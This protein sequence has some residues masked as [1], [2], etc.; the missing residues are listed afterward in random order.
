[1]YL[2]EAKWIKQL[3]NGHRTEDSSHILTDT[4]RRVGSFL[5]LDFTPACHHVILT[6]QPCSY[7][8]GLSNRSLAGWWWN[9]PE[10]QRRPEVHPLWVI[11][12]LEQQ[13]FSA[14]APCSSSPSRTGAA[15]EG[16][17]RGWAAGSPAFSS[18]LKTD[19]LSRRRWPDDL[20]DKRSL[21]PKSVSS[22]EA[23]LSC[24]EEC[25]LRWL[26]G[27]GV[28]KSYNTFGMISITNSHRLSCLDLQSYFQLLIPE[29]TSQ[30]CM[31]TLERMFLI[32]IQCLFF[33][34]CCVFFSYQTPRRNSQSFSPAGLFSSSG[35]VIS[36]PITSDKILFVP[37]HQGMCHQSTVPLV[38]Q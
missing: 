14:R 10:Q 30:L 7:L 38:R 3:I 18:G 25:L 29:S 24:L 6:I 13:R 21:T 32:W 33:S 12:V 19:V 28:L 35:S 34:L 8:C 17:S 26:S 31:L 2:K 27:G 4:W 9:L 36:W 15:A 11:E 1:M 20:L 23:G 22:Q 5:I 37:K 16:I